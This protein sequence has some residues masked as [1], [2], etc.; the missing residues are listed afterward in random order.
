M[1]QGRPGG[2]GASG[3]PVYPKKIRQNT[4]NASKY[5][6]N[7]THVYWNSKKVIYRIPVFKLQ[8]TVY[9]I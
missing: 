6:H 2:G 4:Q 9:P 3:I 1:I 5:T 8:Y 7:Y